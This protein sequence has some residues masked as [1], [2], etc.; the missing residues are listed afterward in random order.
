[1][2]L[3]PALA[4]S[5]LS[6]VATFADHEDQRVLYHLPTA[7]RLAT[8]AAGEPD[9]F[10]LRYHDGAETGGGLLRLRLAL[11]PPD[12]SALGAAEQAGWQVRPVPFDD[13]RFRL[14]SIGD[15]G[16]QAGDWR[17]ATL[18][19]REVAAPAVS[20]T[21]AEAGLLRALLDGGLDVVEAEVDLGWHGLAP[22]LPWLATAATAAL[23][24][25]LAA[26]LPGDRPARVDQVVAAFLSLPD[27]GGEL[28]W[29]RALEPGVP[30]PARD[31]M[32]TEIALRSLDR[33]FQAEGDGY[34]LLPRAAD[35]PARLSWDLLPPRLE[36]HR[37]WVSWS[38]SELYRQL[39]DPEERRRYFPTAGGL[40]PFA[41]VEVHVVNQLPFDPRY[42]RAVAVDL[43]FD[44]PAGVPESRTITFDGRRDVERA[45]VV[46]PAAT[47]FHLDYRLTTTLAPASGTGWPSVHRGEPAAAAGPVVEVGRTAVG[48]EFVRVEAEPAAFRQAAALDVAILPGSP[49]DQAAP[50]TRLT[51]TEAG[52]GAWVALPGV[53]EDA[54]L[55]AL[56][57]ACAPG[58]SALPPYTV[59]DGPLVGRQ[60]KIAAHELEVLGPDLVTVTLAEAS[61]P[62]FAY[63]GVAVVS[64]SGRERYQTLEPGRPWL[65][66]VLR[67]SV[68]E[69]VRFS[70]RIDYVAFDADGAPRPL[71]STGWLSA[72][73]TSLVVRP[74]GTPGGS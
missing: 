47:A 32:L 63:V 48:M 37:H 42:L 9:F 20:L 19:G 70:Y 51:L 15:A 39:T 16:A 61:V 55:R 33:L 58:T 30:S 62:L 73:G 22:G 50:L 21:M 36:G 18:A 43:R 6:G 49:D 11:A 34:R 65:L 8:T 23:K 2:L 27:A 57:V 24:A 56:V 60:V 74:P 35:D 12:A 10:L 72:E 13:G 53:K 29:W 41:A 7:L 69:P 40:D 45:T 64:P 38:I 14:R 44:G 17:P 68:Y 25:Q 3:L 59:R 71:A 26:V 66:P 31:T 28:L 54:E 5:P 46:R 4:D 1:M 52:P 67:A